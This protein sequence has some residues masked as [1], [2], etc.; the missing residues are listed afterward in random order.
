MIEWYLRDVLGRAGGGGGKD[1]EHS[2]HDQVDG[3]VVVEGADLA[4]QQG[5][6]LPGR[7]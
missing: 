3:D 4:G 2:L 5:G 6:A 1:S 7:R